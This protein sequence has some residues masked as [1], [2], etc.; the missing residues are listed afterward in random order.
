[1]WCRRRRPVDTGCAA[2]GRRSAR[3]TPST[4]QWF[5]DR[6]RR[7][8][9][10]GAVICPFSF[11]LGRVRVFRKVTRGRRVVEF[12][13]VD[14]RGKRSENARA[15][16]IHSNFTS[17]YVMTMKTIPIGAV[18]RKMF[19]AVLAESRTACN[20]KFEILRCEIDRFWTVWKNLAGRSP[21]VEYDGC[22]AGSP[23]DSV[24]HGRR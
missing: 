24:L 23:S 5:S 14:G 11:R 20:N 3:L 17:F 22:P 2:L 18:W 12:S 6:R 19:S 10:S 15:L 8:S 4:G 16:K 21:R 7:R 1:M 9:P 13:L